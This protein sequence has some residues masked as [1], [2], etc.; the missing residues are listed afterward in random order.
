MML[1]I[2]LGAMGTY[3]SDAIISGKNWVTIKRERFQ[4]QKMLSGLSIMKQSYHINMMNR[5][6]NSNRKDI[7]KHMIFLLV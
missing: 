3:I 7:G 4:H 5:Q 2:E 1:S 6:E